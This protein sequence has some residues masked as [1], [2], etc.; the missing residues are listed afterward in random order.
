MIGD[1]LDSPRN[2]SIKGVEEFAAAR[3]DRCHDE[4]RREPNGERQKVKAWDT[5]HWNIERVGHGLCRSDTNAKSSEQTGAEVNSNNT[6]FRKL[7]ARLLARELNRWS[8][9]FC[10]LTTTA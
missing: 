1:S 6:D 2:L 3:I 7:N 4:S 5:N 9:Y 8:E 10:V